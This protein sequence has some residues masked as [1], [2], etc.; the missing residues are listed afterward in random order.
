MGK[1]VFSIISNADFPTFLEQDTCKLE[2]F[3]KKY[4]M[5]YIIVFTMTCMFTLGETNIHFWGL[6]GRIG[7]ILCDGLLDIG[8]M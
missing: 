7:S 3:S 2:V 4:F 5:L 8:S 1:S 6:F